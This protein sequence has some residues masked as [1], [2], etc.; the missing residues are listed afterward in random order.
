MRIIPIVR[1]L[2]RQIDQS[3]SVPN[4]HSKSRFLPADIEIYDL[5]WDREVG[6]HQPN[7]L[8]QVGD[9]VFREICARVPLDLLDTCF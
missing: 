7:P 5:L 1:I 8:S 6:P 9:R 2:P 4:R 3:S